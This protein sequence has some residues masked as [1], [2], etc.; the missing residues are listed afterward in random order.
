[1][2]PNCSNAWTYVLADTMIMPMPDDEQPAGQTVDR[3]AIHDR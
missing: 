3:R 1:M 2:P